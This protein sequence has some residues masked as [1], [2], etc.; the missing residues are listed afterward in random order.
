MAGQKYTFQTVLGS[1]Y[2]SVLTLLGTNGQTVIAQNDDM[3]PGNRASC[4][5]WQ[6]TQSG[7]YYL[8][9]SSYP[10]SPAGSFTL[11]TSGPSASTLASAPSPTPSPAP[12]PAPAPTAPSLLPIGNQTLVAG[13]ERDV[14]AVRQQSFRLGGELFGQVCQW[15]RECRWRFPGIN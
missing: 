9:V 7:T 6:A 12:I 15:Q 4:I 1:L 11:I 13:G 14:I 10:G 8:A 3:A 5:T 2:D